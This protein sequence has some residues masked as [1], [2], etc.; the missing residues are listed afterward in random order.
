MML[1]LLK[2]FPARYR[3]K[4]GDERSAIFR[5]AVDDAGAGGW[6]SLLRFCLRELVDLPPAVVREHV[7]ERG[8]MMNDSN[9]SALS[10]T[11]K[12]RDL[13]FFLIPFLLIISLP[14]ASILNS[15]VI[16]LILVFGALAGAVIV[17]VIGLMRRLP[18]W[19]IP[20][21]GLLLAI[22]NFLILVS[23]AIRWHEHVYQ[24][25]GPIWRNSV[26]S[27]ILYVLFM[28]LIDN[29]P[30]LLFVGL[31]LLLAAVLPGLR[32]FWQC[33]RRDWTLLPFLIFT[34][35]ILT[36]AI[37]SDA[38]AG[39]SLAQLAMA[40][41]LV[42]GAWFYLRVRKRE[43]R[44]AVLLGA[45]L[46]S[47]ALLAVGIYILYPLQEWAAWTTFPRWW[48]T[49]QPIIGAAAMLVLLGLAAVV[50]ISLRPGRAENI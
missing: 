8:M 42:A 3:Q 28:N 6:M 33:I 13:I 48:E 39:R 22:L 36:P 7:R 30:S 4:Y 47:G 45:S 2:L 18:L 46:L 50:S 49:L 35:S 9:L 10:E 5:L 26:P 17:A 40:L 27:R 25:I 34:T 20:S 24:L 1:F 43:A 15:Q 29:L 37:T 21:I 32:P 41:A 23:N 44:F 14:L 19:S 38:Y 12:G 16:G 11:V 31:L